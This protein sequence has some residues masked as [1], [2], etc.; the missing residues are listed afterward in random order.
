M[1]LTRDGVESV[2]HVPD[3]GYANKVTYFRVVAGE[4]S[5]HFHVLRVPS[6][7]E[8]HQAA[9]SVQRVIRAHD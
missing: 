7:G 9:S 4:A 6:R 8:A 5:Y 3:C 2:S 1:S